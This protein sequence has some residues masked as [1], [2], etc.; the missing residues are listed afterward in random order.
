MNEIQYG[1]T[2]LKGG[3]R[4]YRFFK[5]NAKNMAFCE[6]ARRG[7]CNHVHT[8]LVHR[9]EKLWNRTFVRGEIE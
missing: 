4:Y 2:Y 8:Y 5:S 7:G 6:R 9:N 3:M 1:V